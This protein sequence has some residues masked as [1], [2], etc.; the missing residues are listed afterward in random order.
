VGRAH[1][2]AAICGGVSIEHHHCI[3][4]WETL[5]K[6]TSLDYRDGAT[7]CRGYLADPE[8]G[9]ARPGILVV[10]EAPGLD[11]HVKRRARMLAE[12]GYVA[13]AADMYGDGKVAASTDEAMALL[14][15]VRDNQALLRG[16]I[17]AAFDTLAG[18]PQVDGNRLAAIGYCFGGMVA[19]ELARSGAAIVGTVSFHGM[20]AAK[21]PEDAR[22]IKGK[23]L[24]CTGA[25]DPI[26]PPEQVRAFQKEMT[27]A[28]VDWQ[29]V[30]YGGAKHAFTNPNAAKAGRPA[31]A[32]SEA[33]DKRSWLAMKDFFAEV[34]AA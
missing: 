23:V 15:P 18:L 26:V 28:G 33:A 8:A 32:Y 22:N 4:I 13:L 3:G 5:M 1:I 31:L 20:L 2:A 29:V 11:D 27:D 6:A 16:R 12:L 30:C 34:L 19:L 7:L 9:G 17:R 24:A 10:H 21:T 25:D 14:A